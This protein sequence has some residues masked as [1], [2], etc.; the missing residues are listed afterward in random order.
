[1]FMYYVKQGYIFT[2]I[3]KQVSKY[4][5][6]SSLYFSPLIYNIKSVPYH[7]FYAWFIKKFIPVSILN[8]LEIF[9]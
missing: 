7:E 2:I 6:L 3:N 1:M 5:L 4:H 9:I 8:I